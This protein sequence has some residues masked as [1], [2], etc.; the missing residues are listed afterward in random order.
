MEAEFF[1]VGMI[2]G[3]CS[4][5]LKNKN[6]ELIFLFQ[7]KKWMTEVMGVVVG[8]ETDEEVIKCVF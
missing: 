3:E 8:S 5:K 6:L 2:Q 7:G 1:E 4:D